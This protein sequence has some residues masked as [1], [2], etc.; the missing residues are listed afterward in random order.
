M[1]YRRFGRTE[2][3]LP[4][5]SCGG[6][7]YQESWTA[8]DAVSRKS[9]RNLEKTL[10]RAL[11]LGIHHV[12]TARGYGTSEAQLG[13]ALESLPRERVI[14]QTKVTPKEDPREFESFLEESFQRLRTETL[15]LFGFHGINNHKFLDWVVRPG[16]CY[17]V[18][19]RYRRDGRIRHVGFSTHA[20]CPV[21]VEAIATGRFDYVNLHWYYVF[22][23]NR[24]ALEAAKAHDMGVF[25]ISPSDKGGQLYR[26]PRKLVQLCRPLSPM[27][28]NDLFC[29]SQ[30][31]I[32]TISIGASKPDD[33]TEHMK[34]LPLLEEGD[35]VLEPI[36]QRLEA[37]Y[38]VALGDAY[39]RTWSEGLPQ[40]EA[41]PGEINV[42]AILRLLN[43]AKAF[44]LVEYGRTRYNALGND[45][46]F[47]GNKATGFDDREMIESLER[48]PHRERIPELLREAHA[49]FDAGE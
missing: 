10:R 34:A 18:V 35:R 8:T 15:D 48:S 2:L 26:P 1:K 47:P 7:R 19:E 5:F 12:E 24:P 4:V 42:Q 6:M 39:A 16:G 41:I 14:L 36:V 46:W 44:D 30:P 28:F 13:R 11:E 23:D 37:A 43:L 29:L 3:E 32:D 49:L 9:Q 25:I 17:E 22:Q 33:F 38:R 20:A 45:H 21:I 27:V 31:G 40:W